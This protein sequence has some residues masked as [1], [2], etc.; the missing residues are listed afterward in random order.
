M[1]T[2]SLNVLTTEGREKKKKEGDEDSDLR[3]R[4]REMEDDMRR[5]EE[6]MRRKEEEMREKMAAMEE[7]HSTVEVSQYHNLAKCPITSQC[8]CTS[9]PLFFPSFIFNFVS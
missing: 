5:K 1:L 4:M 9:H 3:T 8:A 2:R 6:E 7:A